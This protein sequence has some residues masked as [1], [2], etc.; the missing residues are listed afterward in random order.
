MKFDARLLAFEGVFVF[1]A[2]P[3]NH[4]ERR[5][6]AVEDGKEGGLHPLVGLGWQSIVCPRGGAQSAKM[7]GPSK[8]TF[9]RQRIRMA[10]EEFYCIEGARCPQL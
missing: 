9:W 6:H 10:G 7:A 2:P 3:V 4:L 8:A 1:R 5:S